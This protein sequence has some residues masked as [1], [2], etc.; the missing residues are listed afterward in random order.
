[1]H[2]D[3]RSDE[4]SEV[5]EQEE[6]NVQV[7]DKAETGDYC[8]ERRKESLNSKLTMLTNSFVLNNLTN[9]RT[10]AINRMRKAQ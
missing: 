1:M 9:H 2:K 7:E 8:W 3:E 4:E 6:D 5:E 10:S